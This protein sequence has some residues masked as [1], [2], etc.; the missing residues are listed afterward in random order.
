VVA[1]QATGVSRM[2]APDNRRDGSVCPEFRQSVSSVMRLLKPNAVLVF[3]VV[4]LS[5]AAFQLVTTARVGLQP[6]R[7]YILPN[8]QQ[9]TPA[10]THIEVADRPLGMALSPELPAPSAKQSH[11][12]PPPFLPEGLVRSFA[13]QARLLHH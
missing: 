5:S 11:P 7:S 1:L 2:L 8:G 9:I 10:G 13:D 12:P 4:V 3:G 6:D